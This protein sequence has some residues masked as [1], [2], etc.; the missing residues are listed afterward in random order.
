MNILINP[1]PQ[2]VMVEDKAYRIRTNFRIFISFELLWQNEGMELKEKLKKSFKLCYGG[3]IPQ[4]YEAAANALVWFYKCGK[5][6]SPQKRAIAAKRRKSRIYS[7]DYDDDYIYAAF[8]SQ[9]GVNLQRIK[10]LHWWEF[11]AMFN[12][13]TSSNEFVKIMEYRSVD[14]TEDM[15]PGQKAFY[16]KM[17]LIHDLPRPKDEEEK[18]QAIEDA[19]M[20]GGDL[21]GIL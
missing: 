1:L 20:N 7:F 15:P 11:R 14:L 10:Y 17:K 19:L 6:D 3:D 8:R 5:E 13:L 9:Y 4:N 16:R 12:S 18:Q 2:T 21:T